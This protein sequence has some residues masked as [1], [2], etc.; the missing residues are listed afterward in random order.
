[1]CADF[2]AAIWGAMPDDASDADLGAALCMLI[3]HFCETLRQ[4]RGEVIAE[5][6]RQAFIETLQEINLST[7]SNAAQQDDSDDSA[8]RGSTV[9][10]RYPHS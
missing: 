2:V 5:Q 1:M 8:V 4:A 10:R 7:S 6:H 3:A 9:A